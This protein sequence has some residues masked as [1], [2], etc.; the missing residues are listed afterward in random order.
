M[1]GKPLIYFAAPLFS[2]AERAFNQQL[3]D[4]LEELG[5]EVFLPQRDGIESGKEPYS[6]MAP[7]EL[8]EAI[9]SLDRERVLESD[10]FLMV[11]DGRVPDE[12]A[13]VELGLAHA[14]KQLLRKDKFLLG[15]HTDIR[16]A[17]PGGRLNAMVGGSFD[18]LT[19]S[20]ESLLVML[21]EF[22]QSRSG[23]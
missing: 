9:H 4:K 1:N 14:Q 13:C 21:K 2:Q 23:Q 22:R 10:I 12:G 18:C 16:G 11:L 19:D 8:Q 17:F 3:T 5:F 15:L 7:D 6:R 20:E